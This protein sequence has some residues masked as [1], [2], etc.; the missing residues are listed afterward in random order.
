MFRLS[1]AAL[2]SLL[3][4]AAPAAADALLDRVL[5]ELR[6]D[7]FETVTVTATLLGRTR[8]LAEGDQGSREIVINPRTG[9]VLR[10]LWL[11]RREDGGKPGGGSPDAAD[12]EEDGDGGGRG[13][14]RGRGRGGNDGG[15]GDGD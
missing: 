6:R 12:G 7:G 10:D 1:S 8:I 5:R 13:R 4:A 14:G 11:L 2:L 3:L 15:G 9:E